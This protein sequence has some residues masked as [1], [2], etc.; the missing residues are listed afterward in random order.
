MGVVPNVQ[1]ADLADQ[2]R[3]GHLYFD[4]RQSSFRSAFVVVRT[5]ADDPRVIAS[6]RDALR[7]A[8]PELALF[9]VK[10]M[11]GRVAGAR[12]REG[13]HGDLPVRR[14]GACVV[15]TGSTAY[16]P[17]VTQRTREV[18]DSIISGRRTHWSEW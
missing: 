4:Y 13:R 8:D 2:K 5:A 16:W 12:R 18:W 10:T 11:P 3:M 1:T 17:T 6:V 7:Q 15:G 14:A 9:D